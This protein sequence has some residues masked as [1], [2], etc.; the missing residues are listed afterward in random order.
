MGKMGG[1][2][3]ILGDIG[4]AYKISVIKLEIKKSTILE[5]RRLIG[6]NVIVFN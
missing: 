2:C 5:T 3:S 1:A 6:G 4:L